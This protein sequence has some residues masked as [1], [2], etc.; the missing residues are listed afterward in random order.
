MAKRQLLSY[1]FEKWNCLKKFLSKLKG[2]RHSNAAWALRYDTREYEKRDLDL[3]NSSRR[4]NCWKSIF[5]SCVT[6]LSSVQG[7]AAPLPSRSAECEFVPSEDM[8]CPG[9]ETSQWQCIRA[10]RCDLCDA[11]TCCAITW[12]YLPDEEQARPRCAGRSDKFPL[13]CLTP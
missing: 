6:Q 5:G 7:E 3:Q 13:Q 1:C 2:R 10:S 4:V 9:W 12:D 11:A 8:W